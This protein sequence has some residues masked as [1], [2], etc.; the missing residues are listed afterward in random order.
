MGR[1]ALARREAGNKGAPERDKA[2]VSQI[3]KLH[4]LWD[5]T[6]HNWEAVIG[7]I[8]SSRN[9]ASTPFQIGLE[10]A[11]IKGSQ[12]DPE[13]MHIDTR[14]QISNVLKDEEVIASV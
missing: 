4:S 14:F 9:M 10:Q 3:R 12:V 5:R 1:R 6:T 11:I 2:T 7:R 8:I 13:M